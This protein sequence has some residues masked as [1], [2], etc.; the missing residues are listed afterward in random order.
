VLRLSVC[1]HLSVVAVDIC[2]IYGAVTHTCEQYIPI[3]LTDEERQM[4]AVLENAL[5]VSEYTDHVD[6]FSRKS[7]VCVSQVSTTVSTQHDID[8]L[9]QLE[10]MMD[11]LAEIL[12]LASGLQLCNNLVKGEQLLARK[13]RENVPFFQDMFEVRECP[14]R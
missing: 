13:L 11:Q 14:V 12:T 1:A 2:Y 10:R 7:K 6:V 8:L 9:L 5:N 4:L 3:R